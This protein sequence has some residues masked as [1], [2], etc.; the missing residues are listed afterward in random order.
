MNSPACVAEASLSDFLDR[1]T[2]FLF[3]TGKGGVGKTS[4]ACATALGLAAK[5]KRVL[6]VSTDPASNLDEVLNTKL[7]SVPSAI[8][9]CSN[10]FALNLDPEQAAFEYREKMV[11]PYRDKLPAS[12]IRSME[13]QLSG[14]CTVEIAAFNEFSKLIASPKATESFEHVIF[15]TAPTGHTLR[16]LSLPKAWNGFLKDNISGASCLGPLSGLNDQKELYAE[17]M[18]ILSLGDKTTLVLVSRPERAALNEAERTSGELKALGIK[19]QV[20]ILNGLFRATNRADEAAAAL[21]ERSLEAMEKKSSFLSSLDVFSVFL[22]PY[23]LVG[24]ACLKRLLADGIG[25]VIPEE[26]RDFERGWGI[27]SIIDGLAEKGHGVIMTMGKGGVGKTTIAAA[28]AI[29]LSKKGF[30]VHLSTTD[31]AANLEDAL[32]DSHGIKVSRIDPKKETASYVMDTLQTAGKDLDEEDRKVLEEDLRSPCTEEIAV[33]RA[34]ARVVSEGQKGFVVIDTA[35][36]GH[37]LLLLD[38]TESYHREV[39]RTASNVPNEVKD[40]L[41]CLRDPEFT[42]VLVVTLPEATPVHEAKRLQ[43][44]LRRA[45]IEPYAWIINQSFAL[46]H[47]KDPFLRAR[48]ANEVRHIKEVQSLSSRS[49]IIPWLSR[50]PV[51]RDN[52]LQLLNTEC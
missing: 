30:P 49:A 41:P 37:T 2:R 33:F 46:I 21:E 11:G 9:D 48:G 13:E 40:L 25:S 29:G 18:T 34:F 47:S 23:N 22:R 36:T 26:V 7:S 38:A 52:L 12:L 17:A 51:G 8:S 10:V 20:L 5:G 50:E 3:F 16:L 4:L 39:A 44:D 6:L 15:D 24:I 42:R 45:K 14:A 27:G 28:V 31:P 43:E 1:A 32:G 35:P 19:N